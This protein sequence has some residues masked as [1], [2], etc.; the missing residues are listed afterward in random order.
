VVDYRSFPACAERHCAARSGLVATRPRQFCTPDITLAAH[1]LPDTVQD[2]ATHVQCT[3]W[4]VSGVHVLWHLLPVTPVDSN[5]DQP[6][7][8]TSLFL[9]VEQS[10]AVVPSQ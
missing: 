8:L 7:D 5:Y 1:L 10:S 2:R 9:V 6:P 4:P 3:R